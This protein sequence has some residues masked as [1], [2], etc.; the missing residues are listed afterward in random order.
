MR[1]VST[2]DSEFAFRLHLLSIPELKLTQGKD[3][4]LGTA[5]GLSSGMGMG[6]F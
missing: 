4:M 6:G 1:T 3:N 5:R 2:L